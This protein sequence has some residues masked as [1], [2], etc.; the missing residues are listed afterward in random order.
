MK[1]G[2]INRVKAAVATV[3][4]MSLITT[5]ANPTMWQIALVAIMFYETIVFS[6]TVWQRETMRA[7]KQKNIAAG[8]A[9]MKRL[10]EERLY[11]FDRDCAG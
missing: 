1:R 10:S 8:N 4:I 7:K 11:W 2:L 3:W 6:L 9:D 5:N